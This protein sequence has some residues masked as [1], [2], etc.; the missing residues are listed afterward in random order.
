MPSTIDHAKASLQSYSNYAD[1]N[2]PEGFQILTGFGLDFE[3]GYS[4]SAYINPDTKEI[5]ITHRGTNDATDWISNIDIA[6]G[7]PKALDDFMNSQ[8]M[9]DANEFTSSIVNGVREAG[10]KYEG[11]SITQTGHSQGGLIASVQGALHKTPV[12]A[13]DPAA[14][15]ALLEHLENKGTI[16][17]ENLEF[18]KENSVMHRSDGSFI[19]WRW[20][21][22][23]YLGHVNNIDVDGSHSM[24]DIL[25]HME[26]NNVNKFPP[27][28]ESSQT[29]DELATETKSNSIEDV[30][31]NLD[32]IQ[33]LINKFMQN[34]TPQ[35]GGNSSPPPREAFMGIRG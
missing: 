9:K 6:K 21:E 11:Y 35:G 14:N 17:S 10:S 24:S 23:D 1:E 33:D 28:G 18:F 26:E 7:N 30:E 25:K 5:I 4:G 3:S 31:F 27:N 16:T 2:I 12:E 15:K 20:N 34:V 29:V 32:P 8:I 22:S 13:F 19:D